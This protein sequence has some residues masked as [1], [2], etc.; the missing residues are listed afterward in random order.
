MTFIERCLYEY[1][2]NCAAV[3]AMK[4][5]L[6]GLSS[7]H[8]QSY[9]K[10][11]INGVSDPVHEVTARVMSLEKRIANVERRTKPVEQLREDL[12]GSEARF[13]QMRE[14][15]ELKYFEHE[16]NSEAQRKMAVSDRTFRRRKR[17]LLKLASRYFSV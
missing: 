12:N 1:K 15:L 4:E 9:E 16:S 17:E 10:H 8:A 13:Q 6:N 14:L 2:A 11:S 3:S 7:V 5:E